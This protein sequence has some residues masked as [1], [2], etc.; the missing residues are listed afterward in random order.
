MRIKTAIALACMTVMAVLAIPAVGAAPGNGNGSGTPQGG[1][2]AFLLAKADAAYATFASDEFPGFPY[3]QISVGYVSAHHVKYFG[4]ELVRPHSDLEVRFDDCLPYTG[5][6]GVVTTVD[7]PNASFVKL[8]SAVIDSIEVPILPFITATVDLTWT[9][10][11]PTVI[12]RYRDSG[13]HATHRSRAA[14][15]SGTVTI[16]IVLGNGTTRLTF[17]EANLLT[18]DPPE[19]WPKITHY[20]ELSR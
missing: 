1:P 2:P 19:I 12:E 18:A 4:G 17:T 9:A 14:D 13:G 15:V 7:H 8:E 6:R 16:D 5:N 10:T 3:C 11:G 20:T